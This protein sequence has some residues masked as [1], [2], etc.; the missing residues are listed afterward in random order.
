LAARADIAF[1]SIECDRKVRSEL[2]TT[3]A[4]R[5]DGLHHTGRRGGDVVA[6][7]WSDF[8]GKHISLSCRTGKKLW[9]YCPKPLLAAL[10][11]D[12]RKTNG[13]YISTM[14]VMRRSPTRRP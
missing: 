14:P 8:D 2:T 5:P 7:K 3:S 4:I 9:L 11:R 1:V 12:Q 6:M 10:K 13:E